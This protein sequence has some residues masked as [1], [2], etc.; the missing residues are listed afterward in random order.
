MIDWS[1]TPIGSKAN[2]YWPGVAASDV[3]T[4]AKQ[5]YSTHQL[6]AADEHTIECIVPRGKTYVP[7]PSG[8]GTSKG[9]FA[10]LFTVDLPLGVVDR[11]T[12]DIV[13]R[14]ISTRR[15]AV[16]DTSETRVGVMPNWRYVVGTFGVRIPVSTAVAI[17]PSEEDTLAIL[18]WRLD[19]LA[20]DDRWRPVL[21]RYVLLVAGRI[22]GLGGN[23]GS[24]VPSPGG[25]MHKPH[26]R[27]GLWGCFCGCL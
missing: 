12:F 7:I 1:N 9:N 25:A 3:L 5:L 10:G 2:I 18:R 24:I 22:A 11:Q 19:E 4:L 21:Q 6:S 13:V 23:P 8:G 14:R 26:R 16:S 27:K 17:L 20:P 15:T